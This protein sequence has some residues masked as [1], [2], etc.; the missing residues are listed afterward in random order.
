M[1]RITMIPL[2]IF[3]V[4]TNIIAQESADL[5]IIHS[6]HDAEQYSSCFRSSVNVLKVELPPLEANTYVHIKIPAGGIQ[7]Q[8]VVY[9]ICKEFPTIYYP[10]GSTKI[11]SVAPQKFHRG[12]YAKSGDTFFYILEQDDD[13]ATHYAGKLLLS[14]K[15]IKQI[16]KKIKKG[17]YSSKGNYNLLNKKY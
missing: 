8:S 6:N 16:T 3:A 2:L 14:K 12:I 7:I 9:S 11:S 15:E 17:V 13:G 4:I 10:G 1:K 5:Y